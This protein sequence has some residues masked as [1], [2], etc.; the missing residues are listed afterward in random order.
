M[1][2]LKARVDRLAGAQLLGGRTIDDAACEFHALCEG[3]AA[4]EL[5]GMLGKGDGERLW[6]DALGALVTGLT[7]SRSPRE[8]ATR[9]SEERQLLANRRMPPGPAFRSVPRLALG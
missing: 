3:L 4:V 5:R 6:R 7:A 8:A 1:S 9:A 2:G